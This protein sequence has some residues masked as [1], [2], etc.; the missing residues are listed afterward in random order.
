[1]VPGE[2]L[3]LRPIEAFDVPV[4]AQLGP[5]VRE[6]KSGPVNRRLKLD[7]K[8]WRASVVPLHLEASRPL[9]LAMAIPEVELLA[10]AADLRGKS[11]LMTLLVILIALPVTWF[12]ARAIARPLRQLALEADTIRHFQFSTPVTVNSVI[13]E[14]DTLAQTMDG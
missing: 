4:L 6:M 8:I 2:Q 14:V 9:Y 3:R 1:V 11:L 7:G 13:D 12:A 10:A 5:I